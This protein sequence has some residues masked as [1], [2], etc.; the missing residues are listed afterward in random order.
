MSGVR[1]AI[2]KVFKRR[3]RRLGNE[4]FEKMALLTR[5]FQLGDPGGTQV[6]N[7]IVT[8][9]VT[10]DL[11][12]DTL[13]IYLVWRSPS[14]GVNVSLDLRVTLLNREA[15]D[16]NRTFTMRKATFLT[17]YHQN[18][19]RGFIKIGD[20]L[21]H[22][23]RFVD[24][25]GEFQV[26]LRLSK[27]ETYFEKDLFFQRNLKEPMK[28]ASSASTLTQVSNEFH[29]GVF[30]WTVTVKPQMLLTWR[31]DSPGINVVLTRKF[32]ANSQSLLCRLNYTYSAGAEDKHVESDRRDE[33]IGTN[34][35]GIPWSPKIRLQDCY[36]KKIRDGGMV[37]IRID[38]H[39]AHAMSEYVMSTSAS[40]STNGDSFGQIDSLVNAL[41]RENSGNIAV[42]GTDA[43]A[44][45]WAL[46]TDTHSSFMRFSLL[47]L[48]INKIPRNH[49][50]L[51]QWR[52]FLVRHSKRWRGHRDEK[53]QIELVDFQSG[54]VF[55]RY[56]F[57]DESDQGVM[58]ETTIP[59]KEHNVQMRDEIG[60]LKE[61][62][63]HLELIV[64]K[65]NEEKR[66]HPTQ[67]INNQ[68]DQEQ[69]V[70]KGSAGSMDSNHSVDSSSSSEHNNNNNNS[71][72]SQG[73]DLRTSSLNDEIF[74]NSRELL[75]P[76]KRIHQL[77]RS[78]PKHQYSLDSGSVIPPEQQ[79]GRPRSANI[80]TLPINSLVPPAPGGPTM[81]RSPSP[82]PL[83]SPLCRR[84][85]RQKTMGDRPHPHPPQPQA[86]SSWTDIRPPPSLNTPV[87]SHENVSSG[88]GAGAG[89]GG[90]SGSA[91]LWS[92]P[93]LRRVFAPLKQ[94]LSVSADSLPNRTN[95][96]PLV[97]T[98]W[99]NIKLAQ[100]SKCQSVD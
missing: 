22:R 78:P 98:P 14:D 57:H 55:S 75:P 70:K 45:N 58:M 67:R 87:T 86:A 19:N 17:G 30:T 27:V 25:N 88:G 33:M 42:V 6:F 29:Y 36:V 2:F 56:Y 99:A 8:K 34:E 71:S 59:T 61:K 89:A 95:K 21:T 82:R 15:F 43:D 41:S 77:G 90:G 46:E 65:M 9:A 97:K 66:R 63:R 91:S 38:L 96:S 53:E 92:S 7:F 48:D 35:N 52:S 62:I 5:Y 13:G 47:F 40:S 28:N 93:T 94:S 10:R 68:H 39:S 11:K 49:L 85:V 51:V 23:P 3:D 60:N 37:R 20:L 73:K 18:G 81:S 64:L 31:Q 1:R 74:I 24:T 54:N 32:R 76:Q 69:F 44:A 84:V 26:E 80:L 79:R 16:E 12:R 72:S 50:R 100:M 83:R 4:T